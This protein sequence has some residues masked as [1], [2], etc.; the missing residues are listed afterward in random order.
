MK[1]HIFAALALLVPALSP[2]FADGTITGTVTS[3]STGLP[4]QGIR[5]EIYVPSGSTFFALYDVVTNSNGQYSFTI[6]ADTYR[7]GFIDQGGTHVSQF[8]DNAFSV[9][10][11][12]PFTLGEQTL[13]F[14]AQLELASQVSGTV[15]AVIPPPNPETPPTIQPLEGIQVN[16]YEKLG[17]TQFT[18]VTFVRTDSD[19]T[20]EFPSLFPGTFV[21]EFEDN[22]GTGV[23]YAR[24]YYDSK[25]SLFSANE[26]VL[27]A[28]VEISNVNG[29]LVPAGGISGTV[30]NDASP[31]Q[32]LGGITVIAYLQNSGG[33]W[34][35]VG[36]TQ[37]DSSGQYFFLDLLPVALP[38]PQTDPPSTAFRVRF[39]D[40]SGMYGEEYFNNA[41]SIETA[42]DVQVT[43][44]AV[45]PGVNGSLTLQAPPAPPVI[46]GIYESAPGQFVL[47]FTGQPGFEY[48]LESSTNLSGWSDEGSSFT[49][50]EGVNEIPVTLNGTK[51]FWR[52]YEIP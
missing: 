23:Q 41:A 2:V 48:Q 50:Q 9:E 38:S 43:A 5:V 20:Y 33:F 30:T 51:T 47:E 36:A 1:N 52:V 19:G 11:A 6:P 15:T 24:Q 4:I 25:N 46:Q 7:I 26:I 13:V 45:T 3:A 8:Y 31:P 22:E 28:G 49:C 44:A 39:L 32:P 16:I 29:V 14:N 17:P 12:T 18:F 21:V 34:E 10:T 27:T 37:T 42:S 35:A 40:E